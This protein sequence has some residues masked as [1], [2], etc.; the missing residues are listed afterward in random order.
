MPGKTLIGDSAFR[1]VQPDEIGMLAPPNSLDP[2]EFANFKSRAR[3]RHE[4][5]NGRMKFFKILSECFTADRKML[6]V[7][8]PRSSNT[9]WTMAPLF[10]VYASRPLVLL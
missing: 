1:G 4:T 3:C 10:S 8:L 9:K 6:S 5:F 2:T 7:L